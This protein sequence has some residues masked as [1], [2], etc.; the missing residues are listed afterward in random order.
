MVNVGFVTFGGSGTTISQAAIQGTLTSGADV[1]IADDN[2][3][4]DDEDFNVV[5]FP[6]PSVSNMSPLIFSVTIV[7]NEGLFMHC[8]ALPCYIYYDYLLCLP[9]AATVSFNPVEYS[10]VEGDG[11]LMVCLEILTTADSSEYDV[12]VSLQTVDGAKTGTKWYPTI[13]YS[14]SHTYID[15]DSSCNFAVAE[16]YILWILAKR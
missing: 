9:A 15:F 13:D 4:E 16:E 2:I 8:S 3:L 12:I 14:Y 5:L 11:Q 10:G 1:A 7:D 6:S